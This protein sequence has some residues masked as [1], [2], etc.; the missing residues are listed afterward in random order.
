M[1]KLCGGRA[2]RST[3]HPI[4]MCAPMTVIASH[5]CIWW[6][7]CCHSLFSMRLKSTSSYWIPS[8]HT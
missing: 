2:F 1:T 8:Q 6:S 4:T 5:Y 7:A 3:K